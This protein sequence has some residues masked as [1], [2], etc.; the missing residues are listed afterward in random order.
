VPVSV[1]SKNNSNQGSQL[2]AVQ[3]KGYELPLIL[4]IPFFDDKPIL[5]MCSFTDQYGMENALNYCL[6]TDGEIYR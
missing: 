3:K 2:Y 4:G 1:T 5:Q 6:T